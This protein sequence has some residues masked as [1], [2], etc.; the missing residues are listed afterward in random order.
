MSTPNSWV[1]SDKTAECLLLRV[2]FSI[3]PVAPTEQDA[4]FIER[5]SDNST[6]NAQALQLCHKN[7]SLRRLVVT[8]GGPA[9]KYRPMR[10][11]LA[12]TFREQ[13]LD[14]VGV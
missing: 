1:Y 10:K 9:T 3:S 6:A 8:G 13:S 7:R 5:A 11:R 14:E 4:I 2:D 12:A